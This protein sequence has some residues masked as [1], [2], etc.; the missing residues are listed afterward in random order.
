MQITLSFWSGITTA[1]ALF[2]NGNPFAEREHQKVVGQGDMLKHLLHGPLASV[3]LEA[4]QSLLTV[5]PRI[6]LCENVAKGIANDANSN[7][8]GHCA[9]ST[10]PP[11]LLGFSRYNIPRYICSATAR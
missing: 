4:T 9:D 1:S 7:L 2:G 11:C 8:V 5:E 3:W 10:L 6:D